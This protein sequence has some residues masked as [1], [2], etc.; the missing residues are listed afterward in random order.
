MRTLRLARIA[1][2]AEGL[3]LRRQA[4]RTATR[5]AVGLIALMFV[6]WA[7][8]FAHAAAW[9]WLRDS[10]GWGAPGAAMTV[11]GAD[12]VI[13]AF[14]TLLVVR[15][16]PGRVEMEALQV[17]QRALESAISSLAM[18]TMLVPAVRLVL[19]LLRRK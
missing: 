4:Q 11:F 5:V 2:E 15:S 12:L 9:F 19:N 13:A 6:G 17:R 1:A 3:R 8:L 7:L 16:S 18:T 14:L 10:A